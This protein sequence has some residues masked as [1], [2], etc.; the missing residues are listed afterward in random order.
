ME[1]TRTL[2]TALLFGI[3][4]L[5]GCS[6]TRSTVADP[7]TAHVYPLTEE[8]AN[9]IV[10]EAMSAEFSGSAISRVD[11]PNSGYRVTIRFALDSHD[12]VAL[13]IPAKGKGPD[14]ETLDGFVFEVN[15]SGT[16]AISGRRRANKLFEGIQ[17]RANRVAAPVRLVGY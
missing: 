17:Q 13:Y 16:M 1:N 12:I 14:G 11:F 6:G 3:L 5:S 9:L 7:S 10:A 15:D 2:A 4:L 8:Q